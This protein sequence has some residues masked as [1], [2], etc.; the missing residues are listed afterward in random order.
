[1]TMASPSP[2]PDLTALDLAAVWWDGQMDIDYGHAT[3][4]QV[5]G[6]ARREPDCADLLATLERSTRADP[7]LLLLLDTIAET[8]R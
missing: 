4:A 7:A 3:E 5:I 8:Y 6:L 2:T 1:M